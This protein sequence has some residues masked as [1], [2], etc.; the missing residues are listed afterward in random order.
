MLQKQAVKEETI[1]LIKELLAKTYLSDF[2]LVGGTA[3]SL[4]FQHRESI[5]IDL[6]NEND[7]DVAKLQDHLQVDFGFETDM[8]EKNTLKGSIRQIKVDIIAHKYPK[9][10]ENIIDEGITMA[11]RHDIAAM[12][13]NAIAV[14][15]SR[16]KDFIDIYYLFQS[17]SLQEML[18]FYKRKYSQD[19]TTHVL[20]SLVYFH[21][22]VPEDWPVMFDKT[23][24]W[25]KIQKEI[26]H[27]VSELT[28]GAWGNKG[29]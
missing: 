20:K 7:F 8:V 15:G 28:K 14:D 13:L 17:F 10:A 19:N 21:D 3:L 27:K 23:L 4:Q 1:S 6:F 5:D 12:K 16:V 11:S 26:E 25:K 29:G 22:I 9:I 24:T 2:V 18:N